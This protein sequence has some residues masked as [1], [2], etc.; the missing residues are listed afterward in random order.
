MEREEY[1][2]YAKDH[3]LIIGR[4]MHLPYSNLVNE[5]GSFDVDLFEFT[6]PRVLGYYA[7]C[8]EYILKDLSGRVDME[9]AVAAAGEDEHKAAIAKILYRANKLEW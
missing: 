1:L 4:H 6:Y 2:R 8:L 5:D 3:N 7:G 9:V